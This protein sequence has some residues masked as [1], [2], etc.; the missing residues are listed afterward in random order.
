MVVVALTRS[1]LPNEFKV[2]NKPTTQKSACLTGKIED[3]RFCISRAKR[4]PVK[5][6][7]SFALSR[8]TN[9]I[10]PQR[11]KMCL[12]RTSLPHDTNVTEIETDMKSS[13]RK[14]PF[15]RLLCQQ[16]PLIC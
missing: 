12:G 7:N 8:Q 11:L 2:N 5:Y 13:D 10:E 1:P 16:K 9:Y 4:S 3:L 14:A 15:G 6:K